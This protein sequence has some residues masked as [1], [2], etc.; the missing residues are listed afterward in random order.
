MTL[1]KDV[2]VVILDELPP[3]KVELVWCGRDYFPRTRWRQYAQ[4]EC[5]GDGCYLS[6]AMSIACNQKEILN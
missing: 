4:D 2:E 6:M 3:V 5:G 1:F